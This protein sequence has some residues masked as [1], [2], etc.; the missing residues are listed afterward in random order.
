MYVYEKQ[1]QQQQRT[2][3]NLSTHKHI[4]DG[5]VERYPFSDMDVDDND[6]DHDHDDDDATAA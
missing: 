2:I 3:I 1:E 4:D 6:D 5:T